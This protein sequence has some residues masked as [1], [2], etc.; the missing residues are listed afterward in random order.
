MRSTVAQGRLDAAWA[1]T[2]VVCQSTDLCHQVVLSGGIEIFAQVAAS[3]PFGSELKM[4]AYW[5]IGNIAADCTAC[6]L[7][8]RQTDIVKVGTV[9]TGSFIAF[10]LLAHSLYEHEFRKTSQAKNV[11]WC[12]L[13]VVRGGIHNISLDSVSM[14]VMACERIINARKHQRESMEYVKDCIWVVASL[15]DDMNNT[16]QHIHIIS[17][18]ETLIVDFIE[19]LMMVCGH[20]GGQNIMDAIQGNPL[21][22]HGCLRVLGNIATGNNEQTAAITSH[23]LFYEVLTRFLETDTGPL[24]IEAAWLA[25]NVAA[26]PDD[27]VSILFTDNR[28]YELILKGLADGDP[29]M[30]KEGAWTIINML[31]GASEERHQWMIAAGAVSCF[32][33]ILDLDDIRIVTRA[34][35]T[36]TSILIDYPY[37]AAMIEDDGVLEKIKP[38]MLDSPDVPTHLAE[39]RRNMKRHFDECG[40][41]EATVMFLE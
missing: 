10:Q 5:C 35:G 31:A 23:P 14:V 11:V 7:A 27:H 26:G 36:L 21:L 18:M 25:S 28:L 38:W 16:G 9:A 39:I 17:A 24:R 15:A 2:N 29:R 20:A 19:I 8:C 12:T 33:H 3:E 1:L 4:Q 13:N 40:E 22:H 34:L 30:K 37:F 41:G 6:K 32:G